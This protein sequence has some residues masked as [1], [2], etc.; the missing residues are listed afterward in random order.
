MPSQPPPPPRLGAR[1]T[2]VSDPAGIELGQTATTGQ[3]TREQAIGLLL[4]AHAAGL[5]R[6]SFR[7]GSRRAHTADSAGRRTPTFHPPPDRRCALADNRPAQA[8]SERSDL[9]SNLNR[10]RPEHSGASRRA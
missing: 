5:R 3:S 10:T 1:F 4:A 7:T 2:R 9:V 8:A 6:H